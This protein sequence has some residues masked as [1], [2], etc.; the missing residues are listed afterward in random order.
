MKRCSVKPDGDA[1]G[2]R[3]KPLLESDFVNDAVAYPGRHRAL[4]TVITSRGEL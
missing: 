3:D 1:A 4:G 2:G